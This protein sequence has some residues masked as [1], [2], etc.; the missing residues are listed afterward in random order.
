MDD[1]LSSII[2]STVT[3]Y[4]REQQFIDETVMGCNFPWYYIGQQTIQ[5]NKDLFPDNI[6]P[7]LNYANSPFLSHTLLL[8][9]EEEDVGHQNRPTSHYSQFYEFFI[10]IFHRYMTEHN[11]QY[12]KIFRANL[13]LNWHNGFEHTEPHY[14]HKWPHNN[15]IMYLNSCNQGETVIWPSDF[16]TSYMI[17]CI[18]NTAISFQSQWHGHRF[19][20]MGERRVVFVVTYI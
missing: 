15:F 5:K 1:F 19:P 3:V 13:N 7:F 10:E 2:N 4:P 18:K 20:P 16:S 8:R 12:K 14:D 6:K 9:T 11:L 17:P